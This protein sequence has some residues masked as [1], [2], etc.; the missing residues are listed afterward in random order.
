MMD[1]LAAMKRMQQQCSNDFS[2]GCCLLLNAT[3]S[4]PRVMQQLL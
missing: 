4:W 2:L 3:H 1:G